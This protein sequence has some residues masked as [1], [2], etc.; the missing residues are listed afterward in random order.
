MAVRHL[1]RSMAMVEQR[2][3][4]MVSAAAWA[5][6]RESSRSWASPAR[7]AMGSSA[8]LEGVEVAAMVRNLFQEVG[9]TFCSSVNHLILVLLMSGNI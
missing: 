9:I 5:A 6:W 7:A 2:D 3:A 4:R 8:N 1:E